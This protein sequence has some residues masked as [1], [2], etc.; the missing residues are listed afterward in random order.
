MVFNLLQTKPMRLK[1]FLILSLVFLIGLFAGVFFRILIFKEQIYLFEKN[2]IE[3]DIAQTKLGGNTPEET[4]NMFLDA[5]SNK[6]IDLAVQYIIL[7]ER[8]RYKK[9]FEELIK[10]DKYDDE[11]MKIGNRRIIEIP[12]KTGMNEDEKIYSYLSPKDL[13]NEIKEMINSEIFKNTLKVG[14]E[15]R[16]PDKD[17][18]EENI[19]YYVP[20]VI[21]KYNK[22]TNK[23]II[24]ELRIY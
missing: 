15:L 3:K 17:I 13:E 6:N 1:R 21:F 7:S 16:I 9:Y 8:E 23:W 22:Y 5:L 11:L 4:W 10:E 19:P 2:V 12:R 20:Y 18:I 24:K 14:R